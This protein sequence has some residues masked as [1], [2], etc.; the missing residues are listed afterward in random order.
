[1][2]RPHLYRSRGPAFILGTSTS[3]SVWHHQP[4]HVPCERGDW[5]G[6]VKHAMFTYE[7]G[8]PS[9]IEFALYPWWVGLISARAFLWWARMM[10]TALEVHWVFLYPFSCLFFFFFFFFHWDLEV[11]NMLRK[12]KI[13]I[14]E[15][16][17]PLMQN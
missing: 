3:G 1:V 2:T 7:R 10:L 4:D 11:I 6:I 13:T 16:W 12:R 14:V 15:D 5:L 9:N 17:T 8:F